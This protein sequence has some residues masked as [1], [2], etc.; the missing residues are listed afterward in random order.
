[1]GV[2]R[3]GRKDG[4]RAPRC[5]GKGLSSQLTSA[6]LAW[7]ELHSVAPSWHSWLW[8]VNQL[9]LFLSIILQKERGLVNTGGLVPAVPAHLRNA[10]LPDPCTRVTW[11]WGTTD[12]W[13]WLYWQNVHRIWEPCSIRSPNHTPK[14]WHI[15]SSLRLFWTL[16]L[17]VVYLN[18]L[19][20][21]L[22]WLTCRSAMPALRQQRL[23]ET[24][25]RR[26][27]ALTISAI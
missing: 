10:H 14:S 15:T 23:S 7:V 11:A 4:A 25:G 9:C 19:D 21:K 22:P 26:L 20:R 16:L 18:M 8:E 6:H 17:S 5:D 24:Q 3:W 12:G 27:I 13:S 2:G 1:M